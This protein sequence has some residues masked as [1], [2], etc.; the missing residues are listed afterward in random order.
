M[1]GD[2]SDKAYVFAGGVD[3]AR[4]RLDAA[5]EV[6]REAIRV[7]LEEVFVSGR[8]KAGFCWLG[9]A[10]F[11]VVID[12]GKVAKVVFPVGLGDGEPGAIML[13]CPV[14]SWLELVEMIER[15]VCDE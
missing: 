6:E 4:S 11:E 2:V 9:S 13:C 3:V 12:C 5:V 10:E 8:L 7:A 14:G 1:S 15:W